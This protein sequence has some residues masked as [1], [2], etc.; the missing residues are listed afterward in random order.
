MSKLV[1]RYGPEPEKDKAAAATGIENL[2]APLPVTR[3]HDRFADAAPTFAMSCL[4]YHSVALTT[5]LFSAS[6]DTTLN[7]TSK[8]LRPPCHCTASSKPVLT[9]ASPSSQPTCSTVATAPS[10]PGTLKKDVRACPV[11]SPS[12][13]HSHHLVTAS[14]H[15]LPAGGTRENVRNEI[16]HQIYVFPPTF[17]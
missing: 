2:L 10:D 6:I 15:H 14:P 8:T 3:T 1:E 9:S 7:Y 17:N 11:V 5:K 12:S 16:F 13:P 4:P